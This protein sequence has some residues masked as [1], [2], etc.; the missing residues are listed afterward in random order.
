[1]ERWTHFGVAVATVLAAACGSSPDRS[2]EGQAS[3]PPTGETS[4]P[5]IVFGT[6]TS[7][8]TGWSFPPRSTSPHDAGAAV[9]RVL[10]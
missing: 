4:P 7:R 8:W 2:A 9:L 5:P 6:P 1:M 10:P 3:P